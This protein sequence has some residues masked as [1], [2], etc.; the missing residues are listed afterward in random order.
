MQE[1]IIRKAIQADLPVLL[2]FEQGIIATERPFDSTL[3]KDPIH[4]Y[5][6][7][8]MINDAQVELV[9]AQL[10]AQIIGSGY[11]RIEKAKQYLNHPYHAYLG[12]MYVVPQYRGMGINQKIIEAL[13]NWSVQRGVIELKLDVYVENAAAIKAYEKVGFAKLMVQMRRPAM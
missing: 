12:F 1:V 5:D 4:Y 13:K 11:A 9:V 10:G 2:D 8:G 7:E 3:A 6:L